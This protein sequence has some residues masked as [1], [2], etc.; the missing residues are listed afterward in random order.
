[1]FKRLSILL[2]T[3]TALALPAAPASGGSPA[4]MT[5]MTPAAN[6][7]AR[8]DRRPVAGGVYDAVAHK[9]FITWGGQFEDNYIQAYDHDSGT[10]SAPVR[11]GDGDNDSHNYPTIV[12]A[13]DGHLLVFRSLHNTELRVARSPSAHSIDGAWTDQVIPAGLGATYPMPFKTERGAIFVFIRET[14]HDFDRTFPTDT[15]PMK[16]V[17]SVDNGLTW[18][19]SAELTGERWAIAPLDRPDN[20]NEIYIGQLRYSPP[21]LGNP[22]HVDIV[23]TLAGG[24]PEGHL[25]DR[26]H[27][28]MY[29]VSFTPR[30]LH[31]RAADGRDLGTR[32]DN[33]EQEKY[34]KIADTPLMPAPNQ[35]TPDY[36]Q[37]VGDVLLNRPFVVWME[38][39]TAGVLHDHAAV[40]GPGGW[41]TASLGTGVRVRDMEPVDPFTWRVYATVEPAAPGIVTY[42]LHAG[43]AWEYESTTATPR[44]VQRIEVI[45]DHRDPARILATGTTSGRDV[46]IADGDVYVA[47]VA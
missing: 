35:R 27:R 8:T 12:Q 10:W 41:V 30:D 19:G 20:M 17:R 9:T 45:T 37:L 2:A 40:W 44:A 5:V 43:T 11:I 14:A 46:S 22:E 24:G 42:L 33:S 7:A 29:H 18:Q 34:L 6:A 13:N 28:N 38:L 25:H 47:G 36:I 39:D 16:Y 1:M 31:F 15:R 23:Y 32:I 4:A 26:Y 21:R 3:V